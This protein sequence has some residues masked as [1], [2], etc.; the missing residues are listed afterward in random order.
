MTAPLHRLQHSRSALAHAVSGRA[1]KQATRL[2]RADASIAPAVRVGLAVAVVLVAGKLL[3]HPEFAGFAALGAL[4]SAFGRYEPYPRRAGKLALVGGLIVLYATFGAVLGVSTSFAAQVWA[5]SI[6]SGVAALLLAAFEIAGPGPVILIFAA[7]AGVG[8]G[9]TAPDVE[10]VFAAVLVGAVVGW[11]AAMLP[12]LLHPVGPA[13]LA[14][15]RALAAV[16]SRNDPVARAAIA[17]ARTVVALSPRRSSGHVHSLGLVTLL[18]DAEALLDAWARGDEASHAQEVLAHERALRKMRRHDALP[19]R[20]AQLSAR[21]TNFFSTGLARLA[22]KSL[23]LNAV[24]IAAAAALA[25]WCAQAFGFD[26][27]L[28]A[29]M[30]ALAAMQG[31]TFHTTVQRGIQRLL[32][33][34]GGAVIAAGLIA[35]SLGYWQTT[36]AIVVCQIAAEMLVMRNYALTSLAITPMALMMTGLAG[37]LSPTVAVDRVADTL[38]GVLIGVVITAVTIEIGDRQHLN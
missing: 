10:A 9:H 27:P 25:G 38:I 28:W 31:I 14:V 36:V 4:V 37:H 2:G 23:L 5:I 20:A 34:V 22:S 30:G 26:H 18:D 24:R 17:R 11:V 19:V 13:Q 29:T 12:A 32:G 21:P 15:A 16:D 3:G 8:F 6:A 1:W 35:L 7:T 33:N